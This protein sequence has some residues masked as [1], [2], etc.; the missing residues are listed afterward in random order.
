MGDGSGD[1]LDIGICGQLRHLLDDRSQSQ[2]HIGTGVAI[3][4]GE[5]IEF[6]DLLGLI[7]Y[8]FRGNGKAGADGIGNH[9]G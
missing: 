7:G 9:I 1:S 2:G 3:G 5:D 6:V 4:H 8:R